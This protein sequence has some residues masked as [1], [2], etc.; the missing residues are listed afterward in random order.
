MVPWDSVVYGT[1]EMSFSSS[2]MSVFAMFMNIY[3]IS[4]VY[5]IGYVCSIDNEWT[6]SVLLGPQ[7]SKFKVLPRFIAQGSCQY[8]PK[9]K[10]L[11][12][13][14]PH[15]NGK[16]STLVWRN[17]TPRLSPVIEKST[18]LRWWPNLD[19]FKSCMCP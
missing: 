12:L 11:E 6:S 7:V 5:F 13:G 9:L 15:P 17:E 18:S 19:I 1:V 16:R 10:M 4:T 8:W 14:R 3:L 2:N